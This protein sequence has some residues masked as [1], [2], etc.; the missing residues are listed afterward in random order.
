MAT[1]NPLNASGTEVLT[2]YITNAYL[3]A[4]FTNSTGASIKVTGVQVYCKGTTSSVYRGWIGTSL[5][6][7]NLTR[8]SL[9]GITGT[10]TWQSFTFSTPITISNGGSFYAG[11]SST[12]TTQTN[13][14]RWSGSSGNTYY[15]ASASTTSGTIAQSNSA[16]GTVSTPYIKIVYE[17]NGVVYIDNGSSFDAYQVFIDNGTSWDQYIPYVDNGSDWDTC[18]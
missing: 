2:G 1:L 13:V 12:S 6:V 10:L 9:K 14:G 18:V 15:L 11:I 4:K 8:S 16:L 5:S 7:A 3:G 17:L